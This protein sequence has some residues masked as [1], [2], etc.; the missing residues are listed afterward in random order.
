MANVFLVWETDQH[1]NI[2]TASLGAVCT[3]KRQAVTV[4]IKRLQ[5]ENVINTADMAEIKDQLH[6]NSQTQGLETNY[7]IQEIE[8]NKPLL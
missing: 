8:T 2:K 7:L 6:G 4:A 3:S 1:H 5:D